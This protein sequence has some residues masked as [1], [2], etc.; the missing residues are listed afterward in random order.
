[1]FFFLVYPSLLIACLLRNCLIEAN[2]GRSRL[3]KTKK[4]EKH[5]CIFSLIYLTYLAN[6]RA[7]V[8]KYHRDNWMVVLNDDHHA[9]TSII[10][11]TTVQMLNLSLLPIPIHHFLRN[12]FQKKDAILQ[13]YKVFVHRMSLPK[14]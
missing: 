7:L 3:L 12:Y 4:K 14:Q 2:V 10:V 13:F 9:K 6:N 5:S 1:M 11:V 8:H